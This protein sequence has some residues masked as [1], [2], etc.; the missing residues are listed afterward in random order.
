[1]TRVTTLLLATLIVLA[2]RASYDRLENLDPQ[3]DALLQELNGVLE[4]DLEA[5]NDLVRS[6]GEP[7]VV[8]NRP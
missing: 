3:L 2:P 4:S 5:F 7:P 1:M 6:K 8:V